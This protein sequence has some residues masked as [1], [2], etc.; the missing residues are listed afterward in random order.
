MVG[1]IL[2]R[3]GSKGLPRKNILQ[4]CGKPLIAYTIEAALKS[5]SIDRVILS[6]DDEEIAE[7][8]VKYGA[9]VPFM[10]PKKLATDTAAS[11]DVIEYTLAK[12]GNVNEYMLLQPTSPLRNENHIDEAYKLYIESNADSL[13]SI[14]SL[15]HPIQW[16]FNM[17][18]NHI[19]KRVFEDNS[20]QR[21]SYEKLFIPN[22]AIYIRKNPHIHGKSIGYL[23]SASESIDI[24][25]IYDFKIAEY[26]YENK[27]NLLN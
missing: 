17:D 4:F 8:S 27:D 26:I 15:A 23:M 2:A 7:I 19:I 13:T 12:I 6:T 9:E 16:C 18:N 3:G 20:N 25:T 11:G 5:K 14:T 21:Q 22:G 1:L 24:D 10:R